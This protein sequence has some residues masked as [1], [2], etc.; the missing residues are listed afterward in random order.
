MKDPNIKD[1]MDKGASNEPD[2]N[3]DY[4]PM[5]LTMGIIVEMEHTTDKVISEK[6]AKDHLS[7]HSDYYSRLYDAGLAEELD[8]E[9]GDYD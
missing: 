8:K 1:L 4:D 6:I 3:K 9:D 7:E 2:A 5:E